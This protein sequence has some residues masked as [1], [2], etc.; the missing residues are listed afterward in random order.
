MAEINTWPGWECVRVIGSGS[1][2]KVYE[3]QKHEYGKTY[4]AALKVITIP[5]NQADVQSA[6]SDGM[7]RES[8]TSYFQ[9]IV[10]KIT[11]EFA[12]MSD[13]KGYT[14][15]V[16]YQD[17]MVVEH[18]NEIGWD[19]LIRMELLTSLQ[20]YCTQNVLTEKEILKLGCDIC[21]ALELCWDM[22]IIH[23]DIKPENIFVNRHGD[24]ELGD[25][26]VARTVENE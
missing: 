13:L 23:R 14:N 22:K 11:D 25:F 21:Q 7:D 20:S 9:S 5:K 8:V 18:E 19:I 15:I 16:S 2:G 10:T 24:F 12:L 4:T 17:H 3:I 1:Y 6:Y 26:G